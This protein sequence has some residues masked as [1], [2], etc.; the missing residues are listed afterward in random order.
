M[1]LF[2]LLI[3]YDFFCL[4]QLLNGE[5]LSSFSKRK[6]VQNKKY[7]GEGPFRAGA[8]SSRQEAGR[9]FPRFAGE[10]YINFDFF[11]RRTR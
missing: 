8:P 11:N 3:K 9:V 6:R 7:L 5:F 4:K 2:G 1:D 10:G